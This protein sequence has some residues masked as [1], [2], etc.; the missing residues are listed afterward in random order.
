MHGQFPI[1]WKKAKDFSVF[2]HLGNKFI[3]F[4]STI[5]VANIGHS[6]SRVISKIKDLIKKP[7]FHTYNYASLERLDYLEKLISFVPKYLNKLSALFRNRG[8]RGCFKNHEVSWQ[9]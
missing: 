8:N 7:L 1:V 6:N 9:S 3:D 2:D 5:L 4:S